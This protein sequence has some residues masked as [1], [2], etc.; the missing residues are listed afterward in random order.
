MSMRSHTS[1][2]IR[3]ALVL[4]IACQ[5]NACALWENSVRAP[6]RAVPPHPELERTRMLLD[7][8]AK[9]PMVQ[10]HFK[11]D[12][13]RARAEY[14]RAQAGWVAERGD[15]DEEDDEWRD[16]RHMNYMARQRAAIAIMKA[17]GMD[18]QRG[19]LEISAST[20]GLP[21]VT[22]PD[23]AAIE[24]PAARI[25]DSLRTLP[26]LSEALQ[27]LAPRQENRGMVLTFNEHY[28]A[29]GQ[30]ALTGGEAELDALVKYLVA[31]PSS[32]VACEGHSEGQGAE[33]LNQKL[34]QQRARGV[35]QALLERG[36]EFSRVT[37][38][39]YGSLQPQQNGARGRRVEVVITDSAAPTQT[40]LQAR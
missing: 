9:D 16:I 12:I 17:R 30:A 14:E 36:L 34:S 1:A 39:G 28:F 21:G 27:R 4:M 19:I 24:K 31:R 33:A 22:A 8:A 18:A 3:I 20:R 25:P 5:I 38:V 11:T 23:P 13:D 32:S 37:A 15:L 10:Q 26:V 40:G 2:V 29:Q 35:Q 7:R 6:P